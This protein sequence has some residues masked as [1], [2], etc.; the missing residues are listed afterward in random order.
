MRE[1][2]ADS[3]HAQLFHR[4]FAKQMLALDC[5]EHILATDL[6]SLLSISDLAFKW[7]SWRMCDANTAM[8]LKLLS[9]LTHLFTQLLAIGYTLHE[10]EANDVL[11]F[12]VE[13]VLDTTMPSS[14]RTV[15]SCCAS[16][17]AC[18]TTRGVRTGGGGAGQQE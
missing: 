14:G 13:K 16:H 3:F 9:F 6:D 1:L 17:V 18:M 4:D 8:L 5:M 7:T 11:P 10:G 12:V 15:R 2:L